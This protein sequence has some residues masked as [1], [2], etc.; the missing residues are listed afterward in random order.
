MNQQTF[1]KNFGYHNN[2]NKNINSTT[3]SNVASQY[4]NFFYL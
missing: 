2:S 1:Y 3:V 4:L